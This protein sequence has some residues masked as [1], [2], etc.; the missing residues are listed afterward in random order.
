MDN[1]ALLELKGL[2][3]G[4][5]GGN[6]ENA[7]SPAAMLKAIEMA[8]KMFKL[9]NGYFPKSLVDL[10]SPPAGMSQDKWRGPYLDKPAIKD[11]WGTDLQYSAYPSGM[12]LP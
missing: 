1:G 10:T 8:T 11:S 12:F 7:Q 3:K 9:E 4:G 6:R 5:F 2:H